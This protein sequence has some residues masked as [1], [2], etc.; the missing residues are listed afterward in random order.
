MRKKKRAW[1]LSKPHTGKSKMETRESTFFFWRKLK[2][3]K[4]FEGWKEKVDIARS[5]SMLDRKATGCYGCPGMEWQWFGGPRKRKNIY[6]LGKK[7]SAGSEQITFLIG[8]TLWLAGAFEHLYE[9]FSSRAG[10]MEIDLTFQILR[11]LEKKNSTP[12]KAFSSHL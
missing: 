12:E 1:L 2:R 7:A 5:R 3:R 6:I 9:I 8:R 11:R 10:F 4:G